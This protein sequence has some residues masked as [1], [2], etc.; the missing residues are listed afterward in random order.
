M[1]EKLNKETAL[2]KIKVLINKFYEDAGRGFIDTDVAREELIAEIEDV[3]E[4]V[5]IE[6]KNIIIERLELDKLNNK[7]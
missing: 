6:T 3:L 4:K 7:K 5:D 1:T 2:A